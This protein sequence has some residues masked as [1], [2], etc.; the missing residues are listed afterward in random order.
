MEYDV[1]KRENRDKTIETLR[2]NIDRSR[3]AAVNVENAQAFQVSQLSPLS[4]SKFS[5]KSQHDS[6]SKFDIN[7]ENLGLTVST[8][9]KLGKKKC[10]EIYER[11][12]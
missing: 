4:Q 3:A 8:K 2:E 10:D 5:N 12:K 9:K 6:P 11:Q 1:E 7:S